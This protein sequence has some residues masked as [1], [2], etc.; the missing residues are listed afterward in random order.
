MFNVCFFINFTS[1][2]IL[3]FHLLDSLVYIRFFLVDRNKSFIKIWED[4]RV[5]LQY[6]I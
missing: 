6:K 5:K 1:L 3:T 2:I 4:T